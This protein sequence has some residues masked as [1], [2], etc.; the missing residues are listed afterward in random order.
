MHTYDTIVV[1]IGGM[2]SAALYHLARRGVRVLG[3]ERFEVPH[4][5]G[6]SHGRTR[7]IRLAYWEHPA[8]VPLLRRSYEL[9]RDLERHAG[10]PLLTITG[11]IDAG[12]ESSRHVVGALEACH[13]FNLVYEAFDGRTLR[14]RF[15]GYR[16]PPDH[17]AIF[18]PDG[19]ILH[20]ERCVTEHVSAARASGAAI[21]EHERVVEWRQ[22]STA[23]TVKTTAASYECGRLILTAGAWTGALVPALRAELTPE[24]QVVLWT[25]PAAP[26]L[27]TVDRFP[28]FYLEGDE[29]SFY[30]F[31]AYDGAGFKIGKYHHLRQA[32]DPEAM[33]RVCH[34]DDER[35]LREGIRRYFPDADGPAAAMESCLFTN[36]IDEHFIIDV[37]PG[38]AGAVIVAG[39]FSGHGFKFCSVVGEILAALAVDGSTHHDISLFSIT[40]SRFS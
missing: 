4:R 5:W 16:L 14:D 35:I 39:G 24:R 1:G 33:D 26:E 7:I 38:S 27:F 8:Y 11:S 10:T 40:R 17:R 34:P 29:G 15:P 22:T 20:P 3:L 9:W 28:V 12:R 18:Q 21:H 30:G 23:V 25:D 19:G 6:S 13:R 31:P 32:V 36:T 37:V 2:G